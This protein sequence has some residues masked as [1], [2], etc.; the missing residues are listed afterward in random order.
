MDE[1]S[2]QSHQR[3]AAAQDAGIFK[4]ELNPV[5]DRKNHYYSYDSGLR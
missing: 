5:Y 4:D 3:L 1:F 2:L